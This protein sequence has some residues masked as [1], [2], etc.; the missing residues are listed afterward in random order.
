MRQA[1]S[2]SASTPPRGLAR[3]ASA[4][5]M[6]SPRPPQRSPSTASLASQVSR[7]ESHCSPAVAGAAGSRSSAP[8]P[9]CASCRWAADEADA[10]QAALVDAEAALLAEQQARA[11]AEARVSAELGGAALKRGR[12]IDSELYI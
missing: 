9:P 10:L 5:W 11:A 7:A 3:E 2:D 4:A 12:G 8:A 6:V 1:P